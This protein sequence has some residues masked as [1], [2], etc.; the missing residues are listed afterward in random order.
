[1]AFGHIIGLHACAMPCKGCTVTG[2]IVT[3]NVADTMRTSAAG[4]GLQRAT[5]CIS[6]YGQSM[7]MQSTR[8]TGLAL[9]GALLCIKNTGRCSAPRQT[10]PLLPPSLPPSFPGREAPT[11]LPAGGLG[12]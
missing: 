9:H 10:L 8:V 4:V 1:M 11:Q 3:I 12:C 7:R 2:I 6:G 5:P